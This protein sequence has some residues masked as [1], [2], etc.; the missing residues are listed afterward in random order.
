MNRRETIAALLALG[1]T[2]APLGNLAQ[3]QT[4]RKPPHKPPGKPGKAIRV[5]SK[6]SLDSRDKPHRKDNLPRA[7]A[8]A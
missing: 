7:S 6:G 1:A 2:A 3:A 4:A 5:D 8:A